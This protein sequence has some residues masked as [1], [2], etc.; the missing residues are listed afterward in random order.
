M[1]EDCLPKK[2]SKRGIGSSLDRAA[3]GWQKVAQK[4]EKIH[5][6]PEHEQREAKARPQI[7]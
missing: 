1:G 5:F 7:G 2:V 4:E 3:D 6:A